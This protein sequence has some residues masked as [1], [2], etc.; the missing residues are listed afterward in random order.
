MK[1]VLRDLRLPVTLFSLV[2]IFLACAGNA[3]AQTSSATPA[4]S[5]SFPRGA[6]RGGDDDE[7]PLSSIEEEMNAKRAIKFA[8]KEHQE[9]L[10]RAREIGEIGKQLRETVKTKV[11]F[12]REF[13]KKVERLEKLTKKIRE[14]AG[15]DDEEVTITKRPSDVVS[16][17]TQIAEVSETLSKDVKNTP[18]Q[19]VSAS[20]IGSANVLLELIKIFRGFAR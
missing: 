4:P 20:V 5:R 1:A 10:D 19:V 12:D 16:A 9:N 14:E 18:R 13:I 8:E 2:L 17:V 15:G 7:R 11:G 3:I 6:P